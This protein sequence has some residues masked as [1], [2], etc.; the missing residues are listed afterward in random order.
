MADLQER[1]GITPAASAAGGIPPGRMVFFEA[2]VG[3]GSS[4]IGRSLRDVGFRQRY[5][6]AVIAIHRADQRVPGKLGDTLL[7]VGDTLLVLGTAEFRTRWHGSS[8][9]LLVSRLDEAD[10]ARTSKILPASIIGLGVIGFAGLGVVSILEASLLGAL[11]M[12]LSGVLS[13]A[14]ARFAV[15]LDVI[16]LIAA[17]FGLGAAIS[18]TGLAVRFAEG[19]VSG[20]D[21]LG[22][23]V[24]LV[25]VALVTLVLTE[26]ITNN[27]AA[28]LVFPIALAV[29]VE[30]GIDPRALALT[31]AMSAS[32]SFLTPIGY[33][34]NTMVWGPGGY[35]FGDYV[36]LGA[37]VTLVAVTV[38]AV[39][40]PM[41]WTI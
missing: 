19:I 3:V 8:D 37:P 13:T 40:A 18:S 21:G 25:G 26:M 5:Q 9:F 22:G 35:R 32:A 14:E 30:T 29:A 11:A 24:V 2:V 20:L 12:V 41:W 10:P 23:S 36:R 6:A 34:T 28:V 39:F 7:R 31:V 17:S 15:D 27:A 1:N 4:L 33:Q 38:V 16:L